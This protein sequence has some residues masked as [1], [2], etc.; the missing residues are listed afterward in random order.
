M[1]AYYNEHDPGKAAW[2]RELIKAK[3]IA[4][5]DVDERDIEDVRPNDVI[6]F[7]QCH[8][9][10]G[11][12]AW[13]YALRRAGW[14]DD[15]PAWT[16]S[17]PCQPF[18]A[19]GEGTGMSDERHLWPAF[20]HLVEERDPVVIF[21]EQVEDAIK[22]KWLDLVQSDLEGIGYSFA[23]PVLPAACV[24]AP[25]IR[26]RIYWV[27]DAAEAGRRERG[28]H[29]GR[30][31]ERDPSQGHSA[32]SLSG[33]HVNGWWRNAEWIGCLDGKYR[34]IEP[35]TSALAHEPPARILRLRGYGDGIVAE[36][37]AEV[38]RSYMAIA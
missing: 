29:A 2:L 12:G 20:F 32:G 14:S 17:C 9:F 10:A 18:A 23:A 37:A 30:I 13:S 1:S 31:I 38:I 7:T 26:Q 6:G 25:Q 35:G 28:S 21:G 19:P 36:L 15:R 4:P 33:G 34:P 8:W 24:G 5:G 22:Y 11:T 27:A 3:V 16:A